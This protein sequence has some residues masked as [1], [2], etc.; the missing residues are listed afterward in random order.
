MKP[1][2][3][4]RE[5]LEAFATSR[6]NMKI[7]AFAGS[8]KTTTLRLIAEANPQVR[9]LYLAFNKALEVAAK[10]T[11]P[12]NVE[13]RT[14]HSLAYGAMRVAR[15]PFG[16]RLG[17][18]MRPE[19]I[20]AACGIVPPLGGSA[21][22]FWYA[23]RQTVR[24]FQNSIDLRVERG[25]IPADVLVGPDGRPRG[26]GFLNAVVTASRKL[27]EARLKPMSSV[28]IEHDTYLKLWQ[29]QGAD[30]AAD[31]ILFDEAQDANPAMLAIVQRQRC[32]KVFVGDAFQQIY[33]WRGAVNAMSSIE[34]P[35]V[36]KL[37]QSFRFGNIIATMG[38]RALR[39][40]GLPWDEITFHGLSSIASKV[41]SVSWAKPLTGIMRTNMGIVE[42]AYEC[43]QR[44]K[45][46]HVVGDFEAMLRFVESAYALSRGRKSEIRDERLRIFDDWN[47]CKEAAKHEADLAS[48]VGIVEKYRKNFY[49][50]MRLVRQFHIGDE[51]APLIL[52]TAHKAKGR[53][54][55][56]VFLGD[57]F[58]GLAG[59]YK[60]VQ[61]G[62]LPEMPPEEVNLLYVAVTRA[63]HTLSVPDEVLQMLAGNAS[64]SDNEAQDAF[65]N[66]GKRCFHEC[67]FLE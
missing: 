46:F 40:N 15:S 9:F 43:A 38:M 30:I 11:F 23:V 62:R 45:H 60:E 66:A 25:H 57:D 3:E 32:R 55:G 35:V 51:R 53:E 50:M 47:A 7:Q 27:W 42:A 13:T 44:K 39:L 48:V 63:I 24:A 14:A 56:Q 8:G 49:E 34:T 21:Y 31:C 16:P 5:I 28:P 6:G 52:T 58:C 67:T 4:Q 18:Q 61:A 59:L 64:G 36:R 1:T 12:A 26:S 33:S 37:T 65:G 2:E 54:W 22:S 20:F 17:A 10:G 29:L 19:E 41:G